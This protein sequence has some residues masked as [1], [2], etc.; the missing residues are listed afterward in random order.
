MQTL[1]TITWD[2][3]RG[4]D[5][6]FITLRYYSLL[7][8]AGFVLGYFIM[9][10]MFKE[11]GIGLDKLDTLL[12]Y[13]VVATIVGA[14]LGHVF[15]YE[16]DYYSMHPAEIL[17]VWKGGLASH[18]AA[19]AIIIAIILYSRNVLNKSTLWMLDRVVITVALAAA[20]IRVGNWFNSEI[21]GDIDNSTFQ[22]VFL[23]PARER[24]M[25][26]FPYV[27]RVEF[28]DMDS[29]SFTDSLIYPIYQIRF[30]TDT[31]QIDP[32]KAEFT[33][34]NQVAPYMNQLD[35]ESKNIIFPEDFKPD[36]HIRGTPGVFFGYVYGVPRHPTQLYEALGYLFI[37]LILYR[38]YLIQ[39]LSLRRG[40]IFGLFLIMV[41]GFRFFIEY[42]KE[43]QV[44]S[45]VGETLNTGQKLSIPLV[46]TGLFFSVMALVRQK[47]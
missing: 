5:L 16:W 25:D 18:G 23:N 43:V 7:F 27:D 39:N 21:Y 32:T 38:I 13:V 28:K 1:L 11:A 35:R 4:L 10:R 6:G 8:A 19:I 41:F 40:F 37:F 24:I 9:K 33:I 42:Y 46:I 3:D 45:E 26:A 36:F 31:K 15:F 44:A 30:I 22:T 34:F 2:M 12:T 20:L 47:E 29:E 17:K 14:R